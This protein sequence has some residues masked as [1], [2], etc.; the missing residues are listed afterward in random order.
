[1]AFSIQ[2]N[3]SSLIALTNFGKASTELDNISEV[4]STGLNISS[5]KDDSSNFSIAQGIRGEVKSIDA[6]IRGINNAKGIAKVAISGATAVS[7]LFQDIRQRV[8]EGSNPANTAA[9]QLL[10]QNDY[11]SLL[12]QMRQFM[13][14][15]EFN[16]VNILIET[17]VPFNTIV[18]A[19]NDVEV[20]KDLQGTSLTLEGQRLDLSYALL[21]QEDI[22]TA[23]NASQTLA[24]LLQEE[25]RVNNA[26]ASLGSNFR[27][28]E[29]QTRYLEILKDV[30]ETGLGNIVDADMARASAKLTSSQ[31]RKELAAQ[32]LSIANQSPEVF[33]GLFESR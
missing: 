25:R 30:T 2:T 31:V 32:T 5:S 15:S 26:I 1:M 17:N 21:L 11:T 9:Q 23:T 8:T 33:L 24:V 7:N 14:N 10:M 4:I 12:Q 18:G 3:I 22:T 13:E 27:A 28:L 6:V 20:L 19:V 16:G 29:Q